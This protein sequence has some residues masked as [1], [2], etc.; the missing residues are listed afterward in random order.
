MKAS[1]SQLPLRV[2][3]VDDNQDAADMLS[4]MVGQSGATTK[5]AHSG[6]QA[7][8]MA[9][10]FLPH[11]VLLDLDMPVMSG[12]DVIKALRKIP[13]I[14]NPVMVAI[15]GWNDPWT[16]TKTRSHGFDKH[17]CKPAEQDAIFDMVLYALS[18]VQNTR[19]IF[20]TG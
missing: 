14:N 7:L 20:A 11:L 16:I 6:S 2:L 5:T 18:R 8:E 13:G 1:P 9:E 12:Y 15:T 19:K 10:G 3:V 4:L 17:L